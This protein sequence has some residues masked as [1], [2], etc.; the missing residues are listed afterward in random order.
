MI[1]RKETGMKKRMLLLAFI[2]L[3]VVGCESFWRAAADPDSS[4][5][6][7]VAKVEEVAIVAKENASLFGPAGIPVAVIATAI[8][9]LV[10]LYNNKKKI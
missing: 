5:N 9:T 10:G 4:Q 7:T 2:I 6:V 8:T 3:L 1:K